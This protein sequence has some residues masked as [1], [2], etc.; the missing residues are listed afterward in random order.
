MIQSAFGGDDENYRNWENS[1]QGYCGVSNDSSCEANNRKRLLFKFAIPAAI[2]GASVSSAEFSAYQNFAWDCDTGITRLYQVPNFTASTNW[3]NFHANMDDSNHVATKDETRR[4]GCDL[5][6]GWTRLNATTPARNAA[7]SGLSTLALGIRSAN[8]SSMPSSW[9]RFTSDARLSITFNRFPNTAG[10]PALDPASSTGTAPDALWSRD[11]TPTLR[12]TV[13]DPDGGN[14]RGRFQVLNGNTVIFDG[15]SGYVAS[16]GTAQTTVT[17][18]LPV[19]VWLTARA[20]AHDGALLS[21]AASATIRFRVDTTPPSVPAQ[22]VPKTGQPAVYV[23]D[24]WAGGAGVTG[25]F[26]FGTGGVT[27]VDYY[28]YSFDS[29]TLDRTA[30]ASGTDGASPDVMF[31]PT[32]VGSHTLRV[33]SVDF[34]GWTSPERLYRFNVDF[35]GEDA[36]WRLNEGTGTTAADSSG[37]GNALTLTGTTWGNGPF[38]EFGLDPA[39]RAL[40]FDSTTDLGSTAGPVAATN[41]SFTVMGFVKLSTA[42]ATAVAVSQDGEYTSGFKLGYATADAG[43]PTPTGGCWAFTMTSADAPSSG[44]VV[45]AVSPLPVT[46]GQW[47]H[48]TGV[49]DATAG[50]M[51]VYACALGTPSEPAAAEP[52]RGTAP[53][54]STWTAPGAV[55]LGRGQYRNTLNNH[56]PGTVDDVRVFN[57]IVP[58]TTIRQICAGA[59]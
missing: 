20:F 57:E 39:D 29:T 58:V 52:V 53:F 33:V 37:S 11:A 3:D 51:S 50:E 9:K 16:G 41:R 25:A 55:R 8:E 38:A 36:F 49:Y 12:A 18:A 13:S 46:T 15:Y 48:L 35:P 30:D 24:G 14:V 6:P 54:I 10:R 27:D 42:T 21:K 2:R 47:V 44:T 34:A 59:A 43:C 40:V 32:R 45:R 23:E 1:G 4:S 19:N 17:T 5:G 56:W 31:T 22:V 28:R 7:N 26:S